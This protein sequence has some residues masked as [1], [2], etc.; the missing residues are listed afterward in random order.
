MA[1]GVKQLGTSYVR[2]LK[3][4]SLETAIDVKFRKFAA[5]Y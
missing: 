3:H 5:E 4:D 1:K 2:V